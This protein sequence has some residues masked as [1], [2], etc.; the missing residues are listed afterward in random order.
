MHLLVAG[1]EGCKLFPQSHIRLLPFP[2]YGRQSL[3]LGPGDGN[4]SVFYFVYRREALSADYFVRPSVITVYYRVF[5]KYC[6]FSED[7]KIFQTL[8]FL[9]F[10]LGVSVCTLSRQ[11]EYQR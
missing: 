7:F 3:A 2:G 11:V 8:I 6:V 4:L 5:I 1:C 10:S 9:C